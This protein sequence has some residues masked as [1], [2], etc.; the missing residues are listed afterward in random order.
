[1]K[2]RGPAG[3]TTALCGAG[4]AWI[5]CSGAL[6]AGAGDRDAEGGSLEEAAA[7]AVRRDPFWPVGY[8]P[9]VPG[10][11]PEDAAELSAARTWPALPVRGRSRA[12][13]GTYRVLIDGIGVVGE[14]QVVSLYED[15]CWFY[16]R[17]ARIDERGVLPVR[18]GIS[19]KRPPPP[20]S[21]SRNADKSE[22]RKENAR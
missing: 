16:W 1:M 19:R 2:R 9:P 12:P 4:C 21:P 6:A 14:N 7:T 10:Q 3:W 20:I 15:G 22:S 11:A 18:L 17:I 8:V 13:D 5:L